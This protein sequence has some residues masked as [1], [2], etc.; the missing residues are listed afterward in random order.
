M[1]KLTILVFVMCIICVMPI[2]AQTPN[3]TSI[4]GV[5]KDTNNNAAAFAT[6]M[7]LSPTDSTLLNYVQSNVDGAFSFNNVK[8]VAYLLKVSHISF[9]PLQV[10]VPES[11]TEVNDLGLVRIKPILAELMEVVIRTAKAPLMIRGDTI[12]YDATMFKVPPGSSVEDLLKRLPGIEVDGDGNIKTQGKDVNRVY[13]DGKSF[14][15]DDPKNATKNLDAEAISKV[16]VFDEKSEQSKLTGVDDGSKE[17]AMNLQLKEEYKKGSFGKITLAGGTYE[18]WAGRGNYNRFNEKQQLS[19]I[20]YAN[21]INETGV[22]WEDYSEFKGQNAYNDYDNGDFGFSTGG[23]YYSFDDNDVP[24]NNFD[25]KGFTKNCGAGVNYNFDNKKTK[26]NT[27]YFYHYSRLNFTTTSFMETFLR[28]SSYFNHDTSDFAS[29]KGAHSAAVRLEQIIDSNNTIVVKAN[30]RFSDGNEQELNNNWFANNADVATNY[31]FADN[32]NDE[33]S[34]RV[35]TAAIYNHKFKKAGRAFAVSGGYNRSQ[36][37]E[38]EDHLS[39]NLFFEGTS[40]TTLIR[41]LNNN[42]ND[43]E[44]IKS[45]LLYSEPLSKK[46]FLETFYN[47]NLST[48]RVNRQTH[49]PLLDNERVDSLSVYYSNQSMV[50]RL[51]T[52]LRFAH[53]GLNIMLGLAGQRLEMDGKYSVGIGEPLL[54]EPLDKIYLNLSPKFN[55]SYEF[56]NGMW[57]ETDYNYGLSEPSFNDLKPITIIVS[58]NYR[59]EGNVNLVP[60]RIHT[61]SVN[62]YYHNP[63]TFASVNVGLDGSYTGNN[64]AYNTMV[65]WVDSVGYVTTTRPDNNTEAYRSSLWL[66]SDVPLVKTKLSLTL[67]GHVSI[68]NA[69]AYVN[70]VLNKTLS[71]YYQIYSALKIT[72]GKKLILSV[73]G[74]F[75]YQTA[76]YSINTAQNQNI[77]EYSANAD[78][79]WQFLK[80]TFFESNFQYVRYLN[81]RY[82]FN[83]SMPIFNASVR[84]LIGKSNRFQIR[85]AAF[86]IFDKRFDILE[87]GASNYVQRSLSPTLARYFMLSVSYNLKGFEN[88]LKKDRFW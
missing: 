31:L 36:G 83:K 30:F 88:K 16:Q 17:K 9:L 29:G 21:N 81:E 3:R 71:N 48:T 6:V 46:F 85:L 63:S 37:D 69:G 79:K 4:K 49:A 26:F 25:G 45:S 8:N 33:M 68:D 27:N 50:N 74:K 11:S 34:W 10:F 12:E 39:E 28:D 87:Y 24:I 67:S 41:Q 47:F 78:I 51:G 5:I 22:N 42:D 44:Q 32:S 60:E 58:P 56:P 52:G 7:L 84:Q 66:W 64:I 38:T 14:F 82:G 57:L 43:K 54:A 62:M 65:E 70:E 61:A 20:G 86:D 72:P 35:N 59:T 55:L 73:S 80:K 77:I 75:A 23:R 53:N 40:F 18:R 19:F 15:G 76:A 2:H 1:K 13:V